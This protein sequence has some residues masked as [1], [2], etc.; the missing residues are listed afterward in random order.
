MMLTHAESPEI[1]RLLA[2]VK[3][4]QGDTGAAVRLIEKA[5]PWVAPEQ[6]ADLDAEIRR[7]TK[8]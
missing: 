5:R 1:L 7:Y 6:R 8:K 2:R 4:A 3:A